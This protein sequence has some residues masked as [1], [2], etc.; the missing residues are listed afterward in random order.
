MVVRDKIE[1]VSKSALVVKTDFHF[2]SNKVFMTWGTNE[3][4][5][6][7]MEQTKKHFSRSSFINAAGAV[8]G[9]TQDKLSDVLTP[10]FPPKHT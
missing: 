3:K 10:S 9:D 1:P 8:V 4:D 2:I 5:Q 7:R 6:L